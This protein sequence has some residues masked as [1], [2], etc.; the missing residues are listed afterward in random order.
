MITGKVAFALSIGILDT[1]IKI[2]AYYTHERV[3][4]RLSFGRARPTD[5]DYEI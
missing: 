1:A 3:W 5:T 2:G 4:N